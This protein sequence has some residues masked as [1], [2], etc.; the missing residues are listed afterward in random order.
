MLI[1]FGGLPGTGKSTLARLLAHKLKATH[2]RVDTVEAALVNQGQPVGPAGYT[3]AYGVAEDNL[4]LGQTV[5]ADSVNPL[6]ITRRAWREVA[7]RS[8]VDFVEVEVICSDRDEH[9]TAS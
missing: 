5:L 8:Q 7:T 3:V 6:D 4:Q 1:I 2:L 9:K